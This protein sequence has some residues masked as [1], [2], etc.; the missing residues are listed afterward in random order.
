[1]SGYVLHRRIWL[2]L[3][4]IIVWGA[5]LRFYGLDIQSL[6]FDELNGRL[7]ARQ[8]SIGAVIDTVVQRDVHPPGPYIVTYITEKLGDTEVVLRLPSA[9]FGTLSIGMIFLLGCRL[10]SWREGIVASVLMSFL[11]CPI[12]YSQEA[13][14]YAPVLLLSLVSVYFWLAI[15]YYLRRKDRIPFWDCGAYIVTAVLISYLHYYGLY[16]IVLQ[17]IAAFVFFGRTGKSLAVLVL[18][19]VGILAAYLPWVRILCFRL[20]V[21]PSA[22][23]I[24]APK[25]FAGSFYEYLKFIFND[26]C[27][28][29][30]CV[31]VSYLLIFMRGAGHFFRSLGRR[32]LILVGWLVIPFTGVYLVSRFTPLHIL[33]NRYLIISLPAAYLLFARAAVLLPVNQS[34][35]AVGFLFL[36]VIL[37]FHLIYGLGYYSTPSKDQFR[38]AADYIVRNYALHKDAIIVGRVIDR[39]KCLDYYFDRTGFSVK[40]IYD[41]K[42]ERN[43]IFRLVKNAAPANLWYVYMSSPQDDE[44]LGLLKPKMQEMEH[45][46]FKGG[47]VYFFQRK[48]PVSE[49]PRLSDKD[50]FK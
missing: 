6:D 11:K 3:L 37:L 35:R 21:H 4:I 1:M 18:I 36:P 25:S 39:I 43:D 30:V 32:E 50:Q 38:E 29:V 24:E 48:A 41:L 8:H 26:S 47:G 33:V 27:F 31:V 19:Y 23:W 42:F 49:S 12:Y 40:H 7:F 20:S 10:Y 2:T 16:L 22:L 34:A 15:I 13:R 44:F 45:K 46:V 9:I 14:Q 5:G 17:G 28:F